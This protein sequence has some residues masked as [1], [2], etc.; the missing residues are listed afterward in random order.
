LTQ[1]NNKLPPASK[2]W[3]EKQ[4]FAAVQTTA[5]NLSKRLLLISPRFFFLKLLQT[6]R[7][8]IFVSPSGEFAQPTRF[9]GI[10]RAVRIAI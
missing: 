4:F 9:S 1:G 3:Q 6:A 10:Q 8:A 2:Q 7:L 5:A